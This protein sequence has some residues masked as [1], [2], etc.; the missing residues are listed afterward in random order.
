MN[1]V[2]LSLPLF[3]G[4]ILILCTMLVVAGG[5]VHTSLKRRNAIAAGGPERPSRLLDD[6]R[7]VEDL[8]VDFVNYSAEMRDVLAV[9][10]AA[11]KPRSFTRVVHEMRLARATPIE[12]SSAAH[13]TA[14]ALGI[15][16]IAGLIRVKRDGFIATEAGREV[17]LR[18]HRAPGALPLAEPV[19]IHEINP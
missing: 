16:F 19:S 12:T 10:V 11:D 15:L 3:F 8:L 18:L 2:L 4:L 1:P 6:L 13:L 7:P 9:L 17:Q 5:L 14:V